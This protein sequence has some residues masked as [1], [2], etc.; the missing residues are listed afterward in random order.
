MNFVR[1]YYCMHEL[2][3]ANWRCPH[4]GRDNAANARNQAA[5]ALPCGTL[6]HEQFV[7][8]C[9]LGQGGFGITYI[10][11][12]RSAGRASSEKHAKRSNCVI[13]RQWS[14]YGTCSMKMKRPTW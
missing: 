7:I 3:K 1:C 9:M 14:K 13:F 6:L 10:G 12:D 2:D 4:C 8:G 11:W 5:H